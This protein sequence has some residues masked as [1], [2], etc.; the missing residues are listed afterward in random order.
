VHSV[1]NENIDTKAE[2][3]KSEYTPFK[4]YLFLIALIIQVI[5]YLLLVLLCIKAYKR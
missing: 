4:E 2:I 5:A 3:W 1:K